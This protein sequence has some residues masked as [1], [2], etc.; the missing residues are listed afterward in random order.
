MTTAEAFE[1]VSLTILLPNVPGALRKL[2][3][4]T[5]RERSPT[6]NRKWF[7]E[8]PRLVSSTCCASPI[9]RAAGVIMKTPMSSDQTRLSTGWY[10]DS[11]T[12]CSCSCFSQSCRFLL[13]FF[14]HCFVV[15]W[16]ARFGVRHGRKG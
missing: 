9:S 3:S 5:V 4:I 15:H 12:R 8:L 10:C 16:E 2:S 14:G 6:P 11:S 13:G 7:A 1:N